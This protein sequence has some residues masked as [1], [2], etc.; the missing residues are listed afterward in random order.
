LPRKKVISSGTVGSRRIAHLGQL[1]DDLRFRSADV[2]RLVA[3]T[4][5][6]MPFPWPATLLVL[7]FQV[8]RHFLFQQLL[9]PVC[10]LS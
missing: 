2:P 1:D 9:H 3:V 7:S 6:T 4:I 8:I 10:P 5:A